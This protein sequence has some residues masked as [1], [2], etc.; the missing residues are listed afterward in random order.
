MKF[1]YYPELSTKMGMDD[2]KPEALSQLLR[3][4]KPLEATKLCKKNEGICL[5][6]E[7]DIKILKYGKE[8]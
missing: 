2:E 6:D 5:K 3:D 1:I 8:L 7:N 4:L